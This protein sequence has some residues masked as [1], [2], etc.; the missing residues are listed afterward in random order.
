MQSFIDVHISCT[1]ALPKHMELYLTYNLVAQTVQWKT[2]GMGLVR[3]KLFTNHNPK[4]N[5]I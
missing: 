3:A 2:G 4:K 5:Q 1:R